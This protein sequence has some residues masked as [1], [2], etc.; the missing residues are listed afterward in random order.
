MPQTRELVLQ[1]KTSRLCFALWQCFKSSVIKSTGTI[2]AVY[3]WH[4]LLV[5]CLL[6]YLQDKVDTIRLLV[7]G[8][9]AHQKL[10]LLERLVTQLGYESVTVFGDC[11]D[12][13]RCST[14]NKLPS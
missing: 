11:F 12:E 2:L 6:T 9:S 7:I 13:V 5:L 3:W 8:V 10:E 4:T 1:R 14:F